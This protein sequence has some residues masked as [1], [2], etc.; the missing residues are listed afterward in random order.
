MLMR[1]VLYPFTLSCMDGVDGMDGPRTMA[2]AGWEGY[3]GVEG[4]GPSSS[5]LVL[6]SIAF[7]RSF[8]TAKSMSV[9]GVTMTPSCWDMVTLK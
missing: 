1:S 8:E 7:L 6:G 3:C 5:G 4:P 2:S 9:T